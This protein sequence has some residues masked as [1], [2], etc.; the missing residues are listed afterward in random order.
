MGYPLNT[1]HFYFKTQ[2][3][4]KIIFMAKKYHP[5][6][7]QHLNSRFMTIT[8]WFKLSTMLMWKRRLAPQH[9]RMQASVSSM[10]KKICCDW[11]LQILYLLLRSKLVNISVR[12]VSW[13]ICSESRS[14]KYS[15]PTGTPGIAC[16]R[17]IQATFYFYFIFF[18]YFLF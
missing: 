17:C 11:A 12:L 18:I 1:I 14:D 7:A 5:H 8:V 16:G 15:R 13:R 6:P 2:F 4:G 3:S 10:A 9:C